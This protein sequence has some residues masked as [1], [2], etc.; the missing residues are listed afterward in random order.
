MWIKLD[1]RIS[2]AFFGLVL[3]T[4]P[5]MQWYIEGW[6]EWTATGVVSNVV[7]FGGVAYVTVSAVIHAMRK[8]T[9]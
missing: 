3:I 6:P 2:T 9:D 1:W 5:L 4:A 8:E 7:Y